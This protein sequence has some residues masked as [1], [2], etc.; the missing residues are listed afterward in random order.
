MH[1]RQHRALLLAGRP[2]HLAVHV[3][4]AREQRERR[5][6]DLHRQLRILVHHQRHVGREGNLR[7]QAG[8][9]A[10]A[11]R[12]I[13]PPANPLRVRAHAEADPIGVPRRRRD[14]PRTGRRHIHR[15]LVVEPL[16]PADPAR[17]RRVRQ[18]Q[19]LHIALA[20]RHLFAPQ[21]A[22]QLLQVALKRTDR[23]RRKPK[24]R[25]RRIAPPDAQIGAPAAL[26]LHAGDRRRRDRRMPRVRI[27][28]A[29]AQLQP[30]RRLRRQSH[31]HVAVARQILAVD[32]DDPV[33]AQLLRPPR[34][35]HAV[36]HRRIVA[37]RHSAP[38]RPELN[39]H[40]INLLRIP[41]EHPSERS[42]Y[43]SG[44]ARL[45]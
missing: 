22:L 39:R 42:K 12:H 5:R 36:E 27:R 13:H 38:K 30:R 26:R 23:V 17:R 32:V 28:H 19:R 35:L 45:D 10:R 43:R 15:H 16:N 3:R 21:I 24:M 34:L 33:E 14:H 2:D 40:G 37:A 6:A 11:A 29:R 9:V 20:E 18:P 44:G 4:E 41:S 1:R 25:Q 7:R 8:V 31:R